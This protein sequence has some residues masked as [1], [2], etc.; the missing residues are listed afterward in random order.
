MDHPAGVQGARKRELAKVPNIDASTVAE[1]G[2]SAAT[3]NT[4][5]V[6]EGLVQWLPK[7]AKYDHHPAQHFAS[8]VDAVGVTVL[9]D[10][11]FRCV[12]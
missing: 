2:I 1:V 7:G 11:Y 3:C 10:I 8:V 6:R 5:L 4:A 9:R 12:G